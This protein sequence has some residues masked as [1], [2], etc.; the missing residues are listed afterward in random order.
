MASDLLVCA[1]VKPDYNPVTDG[2]EHVIIAK[3]VQDQAGWVLLQKHHMFNFY[4]RFDDGAGN[5]FTG[6][7][8]TPT[9]FAD[10]SLANNGPLNPSYVVV[11]G[12]RDGDTL[13]ASVNSF[14][15]AALFPKVLPAGTHLFT[16]A[17]AH[18]LTIGGYDNNSAAHT[19]GGRV[20]ETAIWNEP[21]TAAN[22]QAKFR[23]ILGLPE[24][25]R[26]TRNREGPFVGP[27]GQYHTMWR[28]APRAYAPN[29]ASG[30]GGGFLFGLQGRNRLTATY[31]PPPF[32]VP[33]RR[34]SGL[35]KTKHSTNSLAHRTT[36]LRSDFGTRRGRTP[37][38]PPAGSEAGSCSDCRGGTG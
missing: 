8:Y 2:G 28:H 20:Y 32:D 31:T 9:Y 34:P 5:N 23:A 24:G 19:F 3:G 1:V 12:G 29:A 14:P 26:Y 30:F 33:S 35:R 18:R 27:D 15:D 10:A 22:I 13:V 21:A 25:A 36:W 4:Y 11:C 17:T 16:G 7:A 6:N 37:R 38:T